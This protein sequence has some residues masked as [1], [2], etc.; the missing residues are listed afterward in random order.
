MG[1]AFVQQGEQL[2]V[3]PGGEEGRQAHVGSVKKTVLLPPMAPHGADS[4]HQVRPIRLR[5]PERRKAHPNSR[6]GFR[7]V[8]NRVVGMGLAW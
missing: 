2:F 1:R 7:C 3:L 6:R 4:I 5:A 8:G